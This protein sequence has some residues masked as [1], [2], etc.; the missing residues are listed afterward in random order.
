MAL[1]SAIDTTI[2]GLFAAL[3]AGIL[4]IFN[5]IILGLFGYTFAAPLAAY[6]PNFTAPIVGA[7]LA[8]IEERKRKERVT[9]I[10]VVGINYSNNSSSIMN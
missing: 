7:Y 5:G 3:F 4:S 9:V 1:F 8:T 6:L 10:A 2:I